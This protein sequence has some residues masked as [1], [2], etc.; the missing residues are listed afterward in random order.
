MTPTIFKRLFNM[1]DG[2]IRKADASSLWFKHE[3]FVLVENILETKFF[4]MY[5]NAAVQRLGTETAFGV[6]A[7]AKAMEAE[8]QSVIHL[9]IGQPDFPTPPN[10]CEA[11]KRA[12]DEG[13]TGY[14]PTC[15]LPEFRELIARH[16]SESRGI[17]VNPS[18]VVV[19]P[20]GK[21]IMFFALLSLVERGEEVVYPDPG[22]PIY[23]SMIDYVGG[24]PVPMPL[25]EAHDF[26]FELD[27]LKGL[28]SDRTKLLILNSPQNPTGGIL[29][30]DDLKAVAEL[31]IEHDV[32]ILADEIYSRLLYQGRFE[33]ITQFPHVLDRTIILD[34]FSKTYSMTGWRLGYGILPEWLVDSFER[35]MVNSNSCTTTFIQRA[36]MEALTGPQ[37]AVEHMR[38]EFLR[39][40]DFFVER[41]N[42]IPGIS[43]RRPKGA[44]YCFANVSQF[45]LTS[46]ELE[47]YLLNEGGVACLAGDGFGAGGVGYLRF[48]FA[49]SMENLAE[50]LKRLADI[51]SQVSR[52]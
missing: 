23:R 11:A 18:Q 10:V 19:T 44:F 15:G 52:I 41:L 38:R 37:D 35:L 21:P 39:R 1:T 25:I 34:G 48:S 36:G 50:A 3:T 31:C 47:T 20:G 7:K 24:K 6:L 13:W 51:L 43:C 42:Q 40:R 32:V 2:T 4:A 26:S 9:E 49:N 45:D 29:S 30:R 12:I 46:R 17:E 27:R 16:I 5:L 8:G 14:G 33:S 22:F 28:I